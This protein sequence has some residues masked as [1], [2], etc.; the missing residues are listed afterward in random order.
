MKTFF[1]YIAAK[2]RA[3]KARCEF[4]WALFAHAVTVI[5]Y[6]IAVII[7]VIIAIVEATQ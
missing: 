6:V 1:A 2:S 7:A 4:D 3:I 5:V